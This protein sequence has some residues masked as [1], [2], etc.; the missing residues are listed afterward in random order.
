MDL[1]ENSGDAKSIPVHCVVESINHV[2]QWSQ[3]Y[4]STVNRSKGHVELDRFVIIPNNTAFRDL[5]EAALIRLGY[6]KDIA[7]ASK[8][9]VVLKNWLPLELDSIAEDPVLTVSDVLGELTTLAT[10]RILVFRES[11]N[12][13]TDLKEKLLKLLLVQSQTQLASSGCPLDEAIILQMMKVGQACPD[14]P[15][16][17]YKKFEQ[18][19]IM[20]S[21]SVIPKIQQS[22][23][24]QSVRDLF[25]RN[26]SSPR[27]T[28]LQDNLSDCII[29]K[30][31]NKPLGLQ[32]V[33]HNQFQAQKTRMRTSFDTELELPKLQAWFA[34]NPHPSRQQIHQ[35]VSELNNLE[36]R[37]GRKPLDVN[38]VV[39]WFKNARA[40]Q[41]RAEVRSTGPSA[42]ETNPSNND[43]S[44]NGY[45][46]SRSPSEHGG[47]S[48]SGQGSVSDAENDD[49]DEF[50]ESR[51]EEDVKPMSPPSEQPISLT[52]HG[53]FSNGDI[54][55]PRSQSRNSQLS[56]EHKVMVIKEEPPDKEKTTGLNNNNYDDEEDFDEDM[57]D[58]GSDAESCKQETSSPDQ[59]S[60]RHSVTPTMFHGTPADLNQSIVRPGFPIV[61]NSMFNHS[62]MYMSQCLP[63]FNM[64]RRP[65]SDTPPPQSQ[66]SQI[67]SAANVAGLNLSALAEERRKRN[68]TFIDP[69]SEVPR[70]EQ[71]FEHNTHPSHSLIA[72]YT[73]ELNRMPYRQKFPRLESKNVQFWFKNRRAKCKRLKMSL[74]DAI[75]PKDQFTMPTYL[76]HD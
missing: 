74:Y 24:S 27:Q 39:Y 33:T 66:Q 46:K 75:S 69:V 53:R 45:C 49:D 64:G 22:V 68:R 54:E 21:S 19:W 16:D 6:S 61:P 35:Y 4:Y 40:A 18:W 52:T 43:C 14:I 29:S 67:S 60:I 2:Y 31:E 56:S 1:Q 17:L 38:N 71:W 12:R 37:K 59:L 63:G 58:D 34:E 28:N 76:S 50:E 73:D 3:K 44:V 51:D 10:L 55:S 62:F 72:K 11:K 8:G 15:E 41:K 47:K 25:Y 13:F 5:T 20:Q 9:L 70:L 36:S 23:L 32:S 42:N 30:N 26:G 7:A 48:Y 57:E 65:Q